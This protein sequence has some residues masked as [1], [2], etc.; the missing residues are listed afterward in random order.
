[1]HILPTKDE[2]LPEGPTV[3]QQGRYQ[4]TITAPGGTLYMTPEEASRLV[5]ALSDPPKFAHMKTEII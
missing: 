5:K 4:V 2:G 1:M 3:L